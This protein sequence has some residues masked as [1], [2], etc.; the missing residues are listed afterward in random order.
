MNEAEG[1]RQ[2]TFLHLGHV[3]PVSRRFLGGSALGNDL[4]AGC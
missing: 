2:R 1:G 4:G 3:C